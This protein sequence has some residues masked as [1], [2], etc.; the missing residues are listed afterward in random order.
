[1][2]VSEAVMCLCGVIRLFLFHNLAPWVSAQYQ[3]LPMDLPTPHTHTHTLTHTHIYSTH[4]LSHISTHPPTHTHTLT[5]IHTHIYTH[6]LTHTHTLSHTQALTPPTHIVPCGQRGAGR[7]CLA[8]CNDLL[9]EHSSI[10]SLFKLLPWSL[11]TVKT[12]KSKYLELI[13]ESVAI[14]E[15]KHNGYLSLPGHNGPFCEDWFFMHNKKWKVSLHEN[16]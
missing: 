7:H 5:H 10:S 12:N 8:P 9:R 2:S 16:L 1:M 13:L 14:C 4:T 11:N 15:P 6:T 3:P